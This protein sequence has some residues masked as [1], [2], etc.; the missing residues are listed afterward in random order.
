MRE[1]IEEEAEINVLAIY[2]D[3]ARIRIT[4]CDGEG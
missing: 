1:F 3:S 2:S 4:L